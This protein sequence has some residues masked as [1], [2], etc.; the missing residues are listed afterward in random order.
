MTDDSPA[1]AGPQDHAR[2]GPPPPPPSKRG[3]DWRAAA[4]PT[5]ISAV[6]IA[7]VFGVLS[8]LVTSAE[9]WPRIRLQFFNIDA[10][11]AAFPRVLQGFWVNMQVWLTV[12]A[13]ILVWALVLAIVRSLRAPWFAPFRL[14][15]VIYIDLFRGVP[16]LLLV[17]LFGFGI[18]ALN[19]P[20]LPSSGL[21][22][23][24][25]AMV[26]SY[27]SYVAEIYRSG[28][29][30]VHEGQ[31][32]AAKSL[33]LSEWQ[34]LRYAILPQALRNVV[35]ALMNIV[36]ALQKD[37]ALLSVIGV[38]DAVREA[39]IYTASTFNYSSLIVAAGLFLLATV[40]MARLADY[41]TQRDR[42]RRLQVAG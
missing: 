18:P 39:Q 35:P 30:A 40:P 38:R 5:A 14:M 31:R 12:L 16:V 9:Q 37:V 41:L 36:V 2:R 13:C 28:I 10:M 15:V 3:F 24:S 23:G 27:A 7:V 8:W 11:I 29:D 34:T 22:W 33:G 26:L 20:G 42:Q 19:L 25:V 32:A 1:Q 17:L 4:V 21:F 6:S